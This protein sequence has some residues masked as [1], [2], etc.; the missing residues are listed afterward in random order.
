[1]NLKS[2]INKIHSDL[3]MLEG[4]GETITIEEKSSNEFGNYVEISATHLGLTARLVIEKSDIEG[5]H[6]RWRYYSNPKD[7]SVGLVER[8]STIDGFVIDV[9]DVFEKRRFDSDYLTEIK[10]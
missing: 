2:N 1:M 10:D 5:G 8:F 6:F 7:E 3:L 9:L 4:I